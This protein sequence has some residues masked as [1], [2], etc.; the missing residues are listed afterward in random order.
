MSIIVISL[1][2]CGFS[3]GAIVGAGVVHIHRIYEST[4][5]TN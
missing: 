3:F 2:S 1:L 5:S 4:Q